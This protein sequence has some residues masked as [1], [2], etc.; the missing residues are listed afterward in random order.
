[1]LKDYGEEQLKTGDLIV[2]T[3]GDSVLQIAAQT[4]L[5][6]LKELYRICE[7][8]RSI[9]IDAPYRIGRVIARPYVGTTKDTFERTSD[10][11]DYARLPDKPTDLNRL[12]DAGVPTYGVGKI[13]DIFSGQGL[14][15]GVHTTSNVDGMN[16][17]I[18]AIKRGQEGLFSPT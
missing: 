10:R 5:I 6:P 18:D 14:D 11:H 17:T 1:M 2:Y 12:Q 3:S 13:N 9:T 4:D 8:V 16:Q 15:D 7:Y